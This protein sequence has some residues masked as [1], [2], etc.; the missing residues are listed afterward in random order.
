M[1]KRAKNDVGVRVDVLVDDV[2]GDVDLLDGQ[3]RAAHDVE[4]DTLGVED[5][6]IQQRTRDGRD[7]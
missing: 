7:L 1:D 2:G 4:D 3:V 6:E 5:G